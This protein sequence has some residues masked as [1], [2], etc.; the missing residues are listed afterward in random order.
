VYNFPNFILGYYPS[1]PKIE[2]PTYE[3][4]FYSLFDFTRFMERDDCAGKFGQNRILEC[5]KFV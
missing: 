4:I 1:K 2:K 5:G 3:I